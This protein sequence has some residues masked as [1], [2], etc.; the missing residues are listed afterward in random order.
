MSDTI[1]QSIPGLL[2]ALTLLPL[3]SAAFLI[4]TPAFSIRLPKPI[5]ALFGAGCG[6]D[7]F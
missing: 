5:A 4:L 2:L 3:V 6:L 1:D 7:Q